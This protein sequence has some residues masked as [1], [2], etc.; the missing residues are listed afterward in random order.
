[1]E[2]VPLIMCPVRSR[3]IF[4]SSSIIILPG[5]CS[6]CRISPLGIIPSAQ[7]TN[8]MTIVFVLHILSISI[9]RSLYLESFSATFAATFHS[10]GTA[11]TTRMHSFLISL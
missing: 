11:I 8:G 6:M 1:M 9:S 7:I 5:N 10:D 3:A 4:C 2:S